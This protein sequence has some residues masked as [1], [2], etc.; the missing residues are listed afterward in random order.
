MKLARDEHTCVTI[1]RT[2]P[3]T[4]IVCAHTL[5]KRVDTCTLNQSSQ[6]SSRAWMCLSTKSKPQ[7][8]SVSTISRAHRLQL[9]SY[10]F[11]LRCN[12]GSSVRKR[13]PGCLF[14]P[15]QC[16][17]GSCRKESTSNQERAVHHW[18]RRRRMDGDAEEKGQES[19]F[20]LPRRWKVIGQ[21]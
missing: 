9:K 5:G 8:I 16:H 4:T 13:W 18:G 11:Y 6:W 21:L 12:P 17:T 15:L 2:K 3:R 19:E 1:G 20:K 7:K 14:S 10:L